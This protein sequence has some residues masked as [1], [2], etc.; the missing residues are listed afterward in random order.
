MTDCSKLTK[1]SEVFFFFAK[2]VEL[3]LSKYVLGYFA[4]RAVVLTWVSLDYCHPSFPSDCVKL[5]LTSVPKKT[6]KHAY[7]VTDCSK[8]TKSSEVFF[9]FA[10]IVELFLSKYALGYFA[11]RA[12]VLTWVSLD[13]CHPNFRS[14]C[15]MTELP[16]PAERWTPSRNPVLHKFISKVKFSRFDQCTKFTTE[17]ETEH[18]W[19]SQGDAAR[20]PFA[21]TDCKSCAG[22]RN[23][24][25][26][27]RTRW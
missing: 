15:V 7:S 16:E 6:K 18:H 13:Y 9:F 5:T 25:S 21:G 3:F 22:L 26:V 11:S 27:W 23:S 24:S 19:V 12:V 20:P 17:T 14:D 1:S 8:L 2:I 10:K 4:S